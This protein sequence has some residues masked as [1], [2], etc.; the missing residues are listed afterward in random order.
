MNVNALNTTLPFP[1]GVIGLTPKGIIFYANQ[2]AV[3]IFGIAL[4]NQEWTQVLSEAIQ[5]TEHDSLFKINNHIV[6]FNTEPMGD[7]NGQ[8]IFCIENKSLV[9]P[10]KK[11]ECTNLRNK[12]FAIIENDQ[13]KHI[14]N[15]ALKVANQ[16]MAVLISGESGTGKEVL[17]QY[18][19]EHSNRSQNSF[20]GINCAAIPENM[21]E[22][23]LFGYEKGA[24]TGAHQTT[25]GKFELAHNGTLLLDEVTEMPLL[26]QAKLLRVLQEREV[27]RIG[28]KKPIKIDVRIIATTNRNLKKEVQEGRFREDLYYRLNVFPI[29]LP[30]LRERKDE[31]IP[32]AERFIS[33]NIIL[34]ESAQK[35]ILQHNWPGNIRELQN[36]ILRAKIFCNGTTILPEDIIFDDNELNH[37]NVKMDSRLEDELDKKE[38]EIIQSTLMECNENRT[39]VSKKLGI[40]TR[41]LRYKI[42]K[43]KEMGWL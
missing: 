37:H 27:E 39:E 26:L 32:L 8:L 30:A 19:H 20:I 41:T 24:F 31:I 18:I 4:I 6:S 9:E 17:S 11:I 25:I 10:L 28:G 16:D 23:I 15:L 43:M 34:T 13:I 22:S 40:S 38:F 33:E 14:Y 5:P 36:V 7:K 42:A 3:D 29:Y 1:I 12:N 2:I 21:L 35:K